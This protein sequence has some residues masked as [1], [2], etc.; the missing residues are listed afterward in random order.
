[1]A[2]FY[3]IASTRSTDLLAQARLI[4]QFNTTQL[5]LQK[6]QNAISTGRRIETPGEDPTAAQRGLAAQRLLTLKTQAQTNA[7]TAQSYLNA[8]DAS[9]ANV[10]KLITDVRSAAAAANSDTATDQDRQAAKDQVD[11]AITQ[12]LNT[13]NQ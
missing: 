11:Q 6:L 4:Q 12:L 7:Q 5:D 2:S 1:M 3:P 13:A 8:T 10:A 9:L